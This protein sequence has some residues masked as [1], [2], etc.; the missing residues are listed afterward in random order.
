MGT[1]EP[2]TSNQVGISPAEVEADT[3]AG[4]VRR[5]RAG[6]ASAFEVL[7]RQHVNIVYGRLRALLGPGAD[8]EDSVQE[9]F[10]QAFSN[11]EK[12]D[13]RATFGAWLRG[14]ALNVARNAMRAK[15]RRRVAM[16]GFAAETDGLR[17]GARPSPESQLAVTELAA[18]LDTYLEGLSDEKRL[19]F[20][21]HYVEQLE[22]KEIA[23]QVGASVKATAARIMRARAAVKEALARDE[24]ATSRRR[25]TRP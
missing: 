15:G 17:L 7:F 10:L 11:L 1:D 12:F 20:I 23:R 14:F 22:V 3:I 2:C 4:V 8:I 9:V 6:D 24:R 25:G 5:C 16:E 13:G 18:K 19:P 21:L